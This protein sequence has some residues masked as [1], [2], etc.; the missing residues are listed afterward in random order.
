MAATGRSSKDSAAPP[1]PAPPDDLKVQLALAC[2][3]LHACLLLPSVD[4]LTAQSFQ[5][6]LPLLMDGATGPQMMCHRT[7]GA[8]CLVATEGTMA[9]ACMYTAPSAPVIKV[10]LAL[11]P[12]VSAW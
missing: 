8:A 2:G 9:Y 6:T 3:R 5:A 10:P 4:V 11:C 7:S 12:S 1:N